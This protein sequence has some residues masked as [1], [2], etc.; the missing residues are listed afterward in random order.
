MNAREKLKIARNK[1]KEILN[2]VK[3]E[4]RGF[5]D[6]EQREFDNLQ[7]EIEECKSIIDAEDSMQITD[8]WMNGDDPTDPP[9][10]RVNVGERP[11]NRN[12]AR[13]TYRE[14]FGRADG[15]GGFKDF[16][17]F[18]NVIR[19]GRY[20]ERL[21]KIENVAS[22]GIGVDGGFSVPEVLT[23]TILDTSLESE[24][25]RPRA[26]IW[27]MNSS[28]RIVPVFDGQDSSSSI[29]GFNAAWIGELAE[30]TVQTP[31]LRSVKLTA[32]KLALFTQASNEL[33][34]DGLGFTKALQAALTSAVGWSMDDAFINGTGVG[35]PLGY[36]NS[37]C[38]ITVAKES[39][40]AEDTIVYDNIV[41]MMSRMLPGSLNNCVWVIS[42]TC[43]PQLMKLSIAIGTAGVSAPILQRT[44]I[45]GW[46]MHGIPAFITE[47]VPT[48]GNAGDISLCD[49]RHYMIGMRKEMSIAKSNAPGFMTDSE[50]YRAIV[51]VTGQPMFSKPITRH[52]GGTVSPFVTLAERA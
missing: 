31:K 2:K 43:M 13:R 30:G 52:N 33:L 38:L 25:V 27:P 10:P 46:S 41:N 36:L 4:K 21:I 23:A 12:T 22:E 39:G 18:F 35:Q 20:D 7:R 9:A 5:T 16:D 34:A 3:T 45:T 49:F 19:S 6:A 32:N 24:I 17:E 26:T 47:K 11:I 37:D 42:E 14:L 40:Q 50:Y 28:S 48:L 15:L 29:H 8:N 1:Q 51:R 44:G